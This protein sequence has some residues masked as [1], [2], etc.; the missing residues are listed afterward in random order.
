MGKF[1]LQHPSCSRETPTRY[2]KVL[3]LKLHLDNIKSCTI[4]IDSVSSLQITWGKTVTKLSERLALFSIFVLSLVIIE[5]TG[6]FLPKFDGMTFFSVGQRVLNGQANQIYQPIPGSG[7]YAYMPHIAPFFSVFAM[8]GL[9][10]GYSL[11]VGFNLVCLFL[12]AWMLLTAPETPLSLKSIFLALWVFSF[13]LW[14]DLYVG[15]MDFFLFMLTILFF[16]TLQAKKQIAAGIIL[17]GLV[18]FKPQFLILLLIPLI[19]KNWRTILCF[20]T[21]LSSAVVM[22]ALIVQ[23][24]VSQAMLEFNQYFYTVKAIS[25]SAIGPV[26]QSF[27]SLSNMLLGG[28]PYMGRADPIWYAP[29][30]LD[31]Q[32]FPVADIYIKIL[33]LSLCLGVGGL[34]L[35]K[36][37]NLMRLTQE[38]KSFAVF[39]LFLLCLSSLPTFSPVFWQV[40]IVYLVAPLA[41][42][43][44]RMKSIIPWWIWACIGIILKPGI[45]GVQAWDAVM[46]FGCYFIFSAFLVVMLGFAKSYVEDSKLAASR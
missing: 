4:T 22:Y 32:L 45:L 5:Y 28:R 42:V 27:R 14:E 12:G 26:N 30:M 36:A 31:Y 19:T 2:A 11:W 43:I 33:Q 13:S 7:P 8:F 39:Q 1:V 24:S 16:R 35:W 38:Q 44:H 34:I 15:Q 20:G 6:I 9:K 46:S 41:W 10:I 17:A 25:D 40:H 37:R 21:T 23:K 29:K 3:D 18:S